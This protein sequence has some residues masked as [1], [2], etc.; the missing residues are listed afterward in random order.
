VVIENSQTESIGNSN[1]KIIAEVEEELK[2][3]EIEDKKYRKDTYN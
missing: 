2:M 1:T 3:D